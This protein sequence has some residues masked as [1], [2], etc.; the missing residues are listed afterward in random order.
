METILPTTVSELL[1]EAI[2]EGEEHTHNV[3]TITTLAKSI[4]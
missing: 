2:L 4:V 1:P 3:A